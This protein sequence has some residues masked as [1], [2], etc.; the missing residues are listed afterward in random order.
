LRR[1]RARMSKPEQSQRQH[2]QVRT[3]DSGKRIRFVDKEQ[4]DEISRRVDPFKL[5]DELGIEI[6]RV[7]GNQLRARCPIHKGDNPTAFSIDFDPDG[8]LPIVWMC[9]TECQTNGDIYELIRKVKKCS[10]LDAVNWVA[11]FVGMDKGELPESM[12]TTH[13]DDD[14]RDFLGLFGSKRNFN[15]NN[16]YVCPDICDSF[17]EKCAKNRTDYFEKRGYDPSIL[18]LFQVGYCPKGRSEWKEDRITVPF[19]DMNGKI[20]GISGRVV[21]ER[22]SPEKYKILSGSNKKE[23]L[24][25]LD[26]ALPYIREKGSVILVEGF[27][28]VWK[29][30]MHG[31]R[32]VV[33]VMGKA[34][35]KEQMNLLLQLVTTIVVAFDGDSEGKM[36]AEDA[37]EKTLN[38]F[39]VYHIEPPDD[40]DIG[41]LDKQEFIA[42]CRSARK[43]FPEREIF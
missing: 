27:S 42:V 40:K 13:H 10:F 21:R 15:S 38:F 14:M 31:V 18:E 20:V 26:L 32:N 39:T 8:K 36:A 11:C 6:F 43:R 12:P 5:C 25:G 29:C 30:W 16:G 19:R 1:R 3:K 33:A 37:V 4:K 22:E 7:R 28:D 9:R 2:S 34:L 24:Y 17:A 41:D 35:T 23:N